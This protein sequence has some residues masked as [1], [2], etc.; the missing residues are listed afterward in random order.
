MKAIALNGPAQNVFAYNFA[1][2]GTGPQFTRP[3]Y[4]DGI[5]SVPN[6]MDENPKPTIPAADLAFSAPESQSEI[7][8]LQN[9]SLITWDFWQAE[10]FLVRSKF[11]LMLMGVNAPIG[12]TRFQ[13]QGFLD[14][15]FKPAM[16]IYLQAYSQIA[17]NTGG[18]VPSAI[19]TT[20]QNLTEG[21]LSFLQTGQGS[22][23]AF[24]PESFT[25]LIYGPRD[26]YR[27]FQLI[28]TGYNQLSA[29][30]GTGQVWR[31][32]PVH[33]V[34]FW[35]KVWSGIKKFFPLFIVARNACLA[36]CA[37]NGVGLATKLSG[38][39]GNA[40]KR[41]WEG[42]GGNY[43]ALLS[44]IT[45]GKNKPPILGAA[46]DNCNCGG[47]G[48]PATLA[49]TIAAA[50][51]II[52]M[53]LQIVSENNDG[54]EQG[55]DLLTGLMEMFGPVLA[56]NCKDYLDSLQGVYDQFMDENT[57]ENAAVIAAGFNVELPGPNQI[58]CNDLVNTL[59]QLAGVGT[60]VKPGETIN[61]NPNVPVSESSTN[62]LPL[63]ALAAAIYLIK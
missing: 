56:A 23:G 34:G 58:N 44:A 27:F 17:S 49:A 14:Q 33:I 37:I 47:I 35:Q 29:A 6:L 38:R 39:E 31:P 41:T 3:A 1:A 62:F 15:V 7:M 55:D 24:N 59:S 32:F 57:P 26:S 18:V 54:N 16:I 50:A 2:M 42:V 4:I 12:L 36:V 40:L 28:N 8:T 63:A 21:L 45:S 60:V 19:T 52:V 13:Y 51:P 5:W 10:V 20:A 48:E 25:A 11:S 22:G 9:T 53:L 46:I 43:S 30:Y 61:T